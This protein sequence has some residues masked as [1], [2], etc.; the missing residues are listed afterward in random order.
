M[1]EMLDH[2]GPGHFGSSFALG[3]SAPN[4]VE[5]PTHPHQGRGSWRPNPRMRSQTRTRRT[6]PSCTSLWRPSWLGRRLGSPGSFGRIGI[7]HGGGE[8]PPGPGI[9][10]WGTAM[11]LLQ[12]VR[13]AA[14]LVR[15]GNQ[16]DA[17]RARRRRLWRSCVTGASWRMLTWP[18]MEPR[19]R[20]AFDRQGGAGL[21]PGETH[22]ERA[23]G[24]RG[25]A[26]HPPIRRSRWTAGTGRMRRR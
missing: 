26:P 24:R 2:N 16:G 8:W 1:F 10:G 5:K 13:V 19:S 15:G 6:W 11:R 21:H 9:P 22:R 3:F 12:A 17:R 4:F 14:S 20:G 18:F 23:P 7:R 25:K